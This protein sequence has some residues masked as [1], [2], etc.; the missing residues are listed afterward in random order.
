MG[1][2]WVMDRSVRIDSTIEITTTEL[3]EIRS[4]PSFW[5]PQAI[6]PS[7]LNH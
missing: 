1:E 6:R 5:V 4:S 2:G 7:T 3:Q